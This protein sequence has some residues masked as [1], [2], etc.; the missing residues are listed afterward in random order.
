M[1][2]Y[3]QLLIDL[4]EDLKARVDRVETVQNMLILFQRLE[5]HLDSDILDTYFVWARVKSV[6]E[7]EPD[8][9]TKPNAHNFTN[10]NTQYYANEVD[11]VRLLQ[12]SSTNYVN[13]NLGLDLADWMIELLDPPG[14]TNDTD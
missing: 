3:E 6:N 4:K 12:I 9:L 8:Y 2:T 7:V 14:E 5:A 1:E 10:A 11:K 13:K